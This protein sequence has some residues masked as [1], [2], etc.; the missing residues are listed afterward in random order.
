M[1]R[2]VI[3]N[4]NRPRRHNHQFFQRNRNGNYVLKAFTMP[5]FAGVSAHSHNRMLDHS[6]M[7]FQKGATY[8]EAA[9]NIRYFC[10]WPVITITSKRNQ[11]DRQTTEK[12]ALYW[13]KERHIVDAFSTM[14]LPP[15]RSRENLKNKEEMTVRQMPTDCHANTSFCHACPKRHFCIFFLSVSMHLNLLWAAQK[16]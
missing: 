2:I 10:V 11:N 9:K 8:H 5:G 15:V 4:T 6:M 3:Y 7:L 12:K 13:S 16:S 14:G 1:I